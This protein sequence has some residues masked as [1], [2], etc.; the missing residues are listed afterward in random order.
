MKT[1]DRHRRQAG[2]TLVELIAVMTLLALAAAI[3]CG[4][5]L[6]YI[7]S[8]RAQ[9]AAAQLTAD[10]RFMQRLAL[11]SGLRTWVAFDV[12][13]NRYYLYMENRANLGKANR[14]AA[15][16]PL[17]LST[18]PVQLGAGAFCSVAIS[19]VNIGGT[20]EVEF[21]TFGVPYNANSNALTANGVISLSSG[22]SVT[23]RPVGG[24]VER[25]T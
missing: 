22:A 11:H 24:M 10:L 13:G 6:A 3:S 14:V 15:I 18:G 19:S 21:D 17:D 5:T 4:I 12:S 20:T 16:R 1:P 2:F 7:N 8:M 23:I 25:G 9:G